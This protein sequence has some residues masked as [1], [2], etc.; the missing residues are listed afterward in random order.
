MLNK[1]VFQTLTENINCTILKWMMICVCSLK[2]QISHVSQILNCL[3]YFLLDIYNM[4]RTYLLCT[5][6][7]FNQERLHIS[8]I[9]L[10]KI[11]AAHKTLR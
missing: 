4:Y 9:V 1:A 3:L 2:Y 8:F 6:T 11:A 7:L 5:C 10:S